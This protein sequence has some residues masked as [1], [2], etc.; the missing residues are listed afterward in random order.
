VVAHV[1]LRTLACLYNDDGPGVMMVEKTGEVE[2]SAAGGVT[3]SSFHFG[4]CTRSLPF[5]AVHARSIDSDAASARQRVPVS[6]P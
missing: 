2:L 3:V 6:V 5:D 4:V 1:S